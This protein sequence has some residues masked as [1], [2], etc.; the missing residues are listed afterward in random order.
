MVNLMGK[1][2]NFKPHP[3]PS[4]ERDGSAVREPQNRAGKIR[5]I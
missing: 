5:K 4:A 2:P 1:F 3:W